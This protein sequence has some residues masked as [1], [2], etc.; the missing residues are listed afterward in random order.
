VNGRA[1]TVDIDDPDTPLL[2]VL[3]DNIGLRGPRFGCRLGQCGACGG[4]THRAA[5]SRF[6]VGKVDRG[7]G[8]QTATM[9][10]VA[11]ELDVPRTC[12][13]MSC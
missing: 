12:R 6:F 11:D 1:V 2:S 5:R 4:A 13:G 8:V 10:I 9:Q 3:R 7:T